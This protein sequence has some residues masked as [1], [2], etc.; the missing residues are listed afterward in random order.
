MCFAD[1]IEKNPTFLTLPPKI[2]LPIASSNFSMVIANHKEI[3]NHLQKG[4]P[5]RI[6]WSPVG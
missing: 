2:F 4:I 6:R 1:D 5:V 3:V